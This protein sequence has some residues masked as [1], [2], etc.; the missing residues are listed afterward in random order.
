MTR[1]LRCLLTVILVTFSLCCCGRKGEVIP[2]KTMA[3]IYA[4]MFLADQWLTDHPEARK[5][6]DTTLF[7]NPIFKK[8][9]YSS[10][11]YEE[12]VRYYIRHP[13]KYTQIMEEVSRLLTA[14]QTRLEKISE[15]Q[16]RVRKLNAQIR[17]YDRKDF[18]DSLDLILYG[19]D[20]KG[21]YCIRTDSVETSGKLP[22]RK[23]VAGK[24]KALQF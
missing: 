3:S 8:H 10:L 1:F 14:E 19:K 13:E 2:K 7:Y 11:D 12:S 21:K 9:G 6:A 22:G 18:A 5:A 24:R 4:E 17:G 16:E 20:V 23:S 15:E